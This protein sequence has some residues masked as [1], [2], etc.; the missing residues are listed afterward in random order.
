MIKLS[1]SPPIPV[2]TLLSII[3]VQLSGI[4]HSGERLDQTAPLVLDNYVKNDFRKDRFLFS[5]IFFGQSSRMNPIATS[6]RS[7][8]ILIFVSGLSLQNVNGEGFR[9]PTTGAFSLG[10]AGG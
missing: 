9:N 3:R 5:S 10:R 6:L 2:M 1:R 7:L 4:T 8:T